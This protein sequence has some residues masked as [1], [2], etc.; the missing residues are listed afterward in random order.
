MSFTLIP[1]CPTQETKENQ[2]LSHIQ[3]Y[4]L[5]SL[6]NKRVRGEEGMGV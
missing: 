3:M 2:T 5:K 4:I 6:I 1:Q